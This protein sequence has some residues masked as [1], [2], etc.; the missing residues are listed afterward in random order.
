[1]TVK[2]KIAVMERTSGVFLP[3]WYF[4]PTTID[5]R[6]AALSLFSWSGNF[7]RG[8]LRTRRM[9]TQLTLMSFGRN[10]NLSIVSITVEVTG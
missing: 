8:K 9:K 6:V 1:M 2:E 4:P 10:L 7:N 5:T 3:H